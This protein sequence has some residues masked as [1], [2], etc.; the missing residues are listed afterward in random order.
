[1]YKRPLYACA[2]TFAAVC[3]AAWSPV[4]YAGLIGTVLDSP[5]STVFPGLTSAAPG[6]LLATVVS[7]YSFTTKAGTTSGSVVS[8]VYLDAD[9][10]LDFYY[11][12]S[13]SANSAS[14]I[15]RATETSF[16]GFTTSVG[17]RT[18]GA[19]LPGGIFING[20]V[21]PNS[22]DRNSPGSV[23]G[24][25]FQP[26]DSAKILPGTSSL[27]FVIATNATGF[28]AGDLSVIDGGTQTVASFE[29][30]ASV[31]APVPEPA[32]LGLLALGSATLAFRRRR[33]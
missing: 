1:M 3:A 22:T 17:Y 18:D 13:N 27:V 33:R 4:S 21:I 10:T 7:P 31:G 9:G 29:P 32:S 6:T 23:I 15:A 16:A 2:V 14:A 19:S 12:I 25:N 11:Q 5:G 28:D 26:P 24:F 8:A 30:T 20:S